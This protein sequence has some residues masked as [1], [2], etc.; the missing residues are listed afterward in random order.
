M[1]T[2]IR[3]MLSP[4]NPYHISKHRQYELKHFCLQ[5]PEWKKSYLALD[6]FA[7]PAAGVVP[8]N[9]DP[10]DP[11]A[12][13]AIAKVFYSRRMAMIEEAAAK[14]DPELSRYII[15]AVTEELSYECLKSRYDIPCCRDTYYDRY[16]KFFWILSDM[17]K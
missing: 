1:S 8:A 5:Y 4:K 13:C 2:K 17:R 6:G 15:K 12:R 11:T 16:R 14:A 7:R 3:P 9:C 10:D